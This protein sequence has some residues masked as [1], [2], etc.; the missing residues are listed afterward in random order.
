MPFEEYLLLLGP[1]LSDPELS[2]RGLVQSQ[3]QSL[4]PSSFAHW[5]EKHCQHGADVVAN[6]LAHDKVQ[7]V[8][9]F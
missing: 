9:I 4:F 5:A 8:M 7:A 6:L 1:D 2:Q 3:V